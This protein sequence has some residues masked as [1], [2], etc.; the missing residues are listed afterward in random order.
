MQGMSV[1]F[2]FFEGGG[3]GWL[4]RV[5]VVFPFF[6]VYIYTHTYYAISLYIYNI[7]LYIYV[8]TRTL[9]CSDGR[10]EM[11]LHST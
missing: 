6:F 4:C 8:Y 11:T 10:A 5:H 2:S 3:R 1:F 7:H 9:M